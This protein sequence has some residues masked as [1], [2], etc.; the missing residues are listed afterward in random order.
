M[1]SKLTTTESAV[2]AI[3]F[4]TLTAIPGNLMYKGARI[5]LLDTPGIIEGAA[6]GKGKGRQVVA[7]ARTADVLLVM[8]DPT[9]EI[10]QKHIIEH[11]LD[12]VGIRINQTPPDIVVSKKKTG[13]ISFNSSV[14]L[15]Q[16]DGDMIKT[17]LHEY[18]MFFL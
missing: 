7:T 12:S 5:Q 10:A 1:L 13:G 4:T 14:P 8:L 3:E 9:R 11:E 15:T 2:S 18:S 16:I 17:I 6:Q